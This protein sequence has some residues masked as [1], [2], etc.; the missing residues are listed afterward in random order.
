MKTKEIP[1]PSIS[2]TKD[3]PTDLN[4][5]KMLAVANEQ[6]GNLKTAEEIYEKITS[7]TK[8]AEDY[9]KVGLI[10]FKLKKYKEAIKAFDDTILIDPNHKKAY[11]NKGTVLI[12]L[13]E[14]K[15]AIKAFEKAIAIDQTYDTAFYNKGLAEEKKR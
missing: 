1:K 9:Y 5:L 3:T 8:K 13:D 14:P 2:P 12:I 7:I 4:S 11:T 10:K 15:E 6:K